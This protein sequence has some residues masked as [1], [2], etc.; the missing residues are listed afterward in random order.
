MPLAPAQGRGRPPLTPRSRGTLPVRARQM[1]LRDQ[2]ALPFMLPK[3]RGRREAEPSI[4]GDFRGAKHIF[5][6]RELFPFRL[7]KRPPFMCLIEEQVLP[8]EIHYFESDIRLL[9]E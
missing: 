9:P 6:F 4:E 8:Q 1:R 5:L 7:G 3:N 2:F